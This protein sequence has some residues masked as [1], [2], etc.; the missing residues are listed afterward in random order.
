M[1]SKKRQPRRRPPSPVLVR[2]RGSSR[3]RARAIWLLADR[4]AQT[5]HHRD[6]PFAD[7]E[8]CTSGLCPPCQRTRSR[9]GNTSA[10]SSK[11]VMSSAITLEPPLG[12]HREL[13]QRFLAQIMAD[14]CVIHSSNRT[15]P[16]PHG[17]RHLAKERLR[18]KSCEHPPQVGPGWPWC[19]DH[20]GHVE[21]D[22]SPPR[23]AR[24]GQGCPRSG[25]ATAGPSPI[26]RAQ[27]L[28]PRRQKRQVE[29]G[30]SGGG[31]IDAQRARISARS[32][33]GIGMRR[34]NLAG[35]RQRAVAQRS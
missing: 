3:P 18:R 13:G 15:R 29:G 19:E 25:I 1:R 30:V 31:R 35:K 27:A 23:P 22:R 7:G 20:M 12:P 33:F 11:S 16:R 6:R 4:I 10:P 21:R 26:G 2:A 32:F 14:G 8:A 5:P 9:P 24:R 34:L 28:S 17:L